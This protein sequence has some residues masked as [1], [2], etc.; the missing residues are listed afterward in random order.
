MEEVV[1]LYTEDQGFPP[2]SHHHALPEF[3][4]GDLLKSV[5]PLMH[6]CGSHQHTLVFES[7]AA[8][9]AVALPLRQ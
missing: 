2:H 8:M 1:T 9:V 3:L 6:G 4:A 7:L 5:Q